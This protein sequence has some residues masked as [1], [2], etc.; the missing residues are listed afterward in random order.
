[1]PRKLG[2]VV[3]TD[4]INDRIADDE[5]FARL[6]TKCLKRYIHYDWGDLCD[7]E[8]RMNDLA[9]KNGDDRILASYNNPDGGRVWIITEWD[10]SITT[11]LLPEEY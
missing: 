5:H 9:V 10:H 3:M 11:I 7:G 4:G 6:I 1:M 2:Q 8:R